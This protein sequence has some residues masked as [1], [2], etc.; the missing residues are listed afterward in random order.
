MVIVIYDNDIIDFIIVIVQFLFCFVFTLL[1]CEVIVDIV[2]YKQYKN[3]IFI[4]LF[5]FIFSII[6]KSI[7]KEVNMTLSDYIKLLMKKN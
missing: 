7:T 1:I 5:I 3:I 4:C 6:Y 2:I